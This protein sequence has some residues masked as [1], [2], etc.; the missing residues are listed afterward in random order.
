[1][2]LPCAEE[3]LGLVRCEERPWCWEV[4]EVDSGGE[5]GRLEAGEEERGMECMESV[6]CVVLLARPP[7]PPPFSAAAAAARDAELRIRYTYG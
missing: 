7:P 6:V 5:T 2:P 1:M 4:A 3:R